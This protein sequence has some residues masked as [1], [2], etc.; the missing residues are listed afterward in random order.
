MAKEEEEG[1]CKVAG[2]SSVATGDGAGDGA[3]G[4]TGNGIGGCSCS[5][6]VTFK[7][8]EALDSTNCDNRCSFWLLIEEVPKLF[9]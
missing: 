2:D 5:C 1:W 4:G 7:R 6:S 9:R 8:V 3:G